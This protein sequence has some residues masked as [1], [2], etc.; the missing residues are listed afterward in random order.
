MIPKMYPTLDLQLQTSFVRIDTK[1]RRETSHHDSAFK[2]A[3][4][5]PLNDLSRVDVME[6]T[7]RN[8]ERCKLCVLQEYYIL[9]ESSKISHI[10]FAEQLA[11]F[12]QMREVQRNVN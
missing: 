12:I 3:F 6:R 1:P 2:T 7:G 10:S 11:P 5:L 4:A 9:V 8:E